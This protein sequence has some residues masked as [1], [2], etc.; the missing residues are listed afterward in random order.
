[1]ELD[2]SSPKCAIISRFFSYQSVHN[3]QYTY[4]CTPISLCSKIRFLL[5]RK[6][7][8]MMLVCNC[9]NTHFFIHFYYTRKWS[10]MWYITVVRTDSGLEIEKKWA[11][12]LNSKTLI[13]NT[14]DFF[15]HI[16][17]TNSDSNKFNISKNSEAFLALFW[18]FLANCVTEWNGKE[19][20]IASKQWDSSKALCVQAI[21]FFL[22][23]TLS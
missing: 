6:I 4:V 9:C 3:I 10:T 19:A 7:W 18:Q 23:L 13:N 11:L 12:V 8:F 2:S 14:S 21:R 22:A 20:K 17:V 15:F 5:S 1:M 16:T